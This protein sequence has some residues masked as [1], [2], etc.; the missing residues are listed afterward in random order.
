MGGNVQTIM[1]DLFDFF[2][3]IKY[4]HREEFVLNDGGKIYLDYKG[5]CLKRSEETYIEDENNKNPVLFV[6]PGLT[7]HS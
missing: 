4:D 2:N 1:G 3:G 6:C 7:S 5:K